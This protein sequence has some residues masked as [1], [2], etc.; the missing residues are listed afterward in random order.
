MEEIVVVVN[1][2]VRSRGLPK[3]L[4]IVDKAH[5]VT[6]SQLDVRSPAGPRR[7]GTLSVLAGRTR[8]STRRASAAGLGKVPECGL[9]PESGERA[10]N[11]HGTA[12][13]PELH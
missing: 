7:D 5:D 9:I 3:S 4:L 11:H 13:G 2:I 12:K 10:G 1:R 6:G 8:K